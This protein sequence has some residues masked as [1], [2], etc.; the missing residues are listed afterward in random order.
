LFP[1]GF[2]EP[3]EDIVNALA[4]VLELGE[5]LVEGRMLRF[6][7]EEGADSEGERLVSG[8]DEGS[9]CVGLKLKAFA[10]TL[11]V[12]EPEVELVGG[13][14]GWGFADSY[15]HTSISHTC[16]GFVTS[17]TDF[18]GFFGHLKTTMARL[19]EG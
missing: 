1:V 7:W 2:E 19:L 17:K 6:L 4:S 12:D 9:L 3:V 14:A 8:G 13:A 16:A 15:F 18:E 5:P 11:T 10:D